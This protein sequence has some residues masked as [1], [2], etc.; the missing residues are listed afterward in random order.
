MRA[1]WLVLSSR[2]STFCF[3][4]IF[5][6]IFLEVSE[7]NLIRIILNIK[8]IIFR[9]IR[10]PKSTKI[11]LGLGLVISYII[12]GALTWFYKLEGAYMVLLE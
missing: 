4:C 5:T 8:E 6:C 7:I 9:I 3:R 2:L 1:T 11:V 10:F 12:P